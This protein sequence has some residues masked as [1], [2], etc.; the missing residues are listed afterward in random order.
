MSKPT[1]SAF[2]KISFEEAANVIYYQFGSKP[3][4]MFKELMEELICHPEEPHKCL[5]RKWYEDYKQ[6]LTDN[7]KEA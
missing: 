3:P 4:G 6:M 5:C 1:L 7:K 2:E